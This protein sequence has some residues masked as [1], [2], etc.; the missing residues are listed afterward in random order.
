MIAIGKSISHI[1]ASISY[2][3]KSEK[4]ILLDKNIVSETPHGVS[5]EFRLFQDLNSRCERNT[6]SFVISPSIKDGNRLS[7]EALKAINQSFLEKM[8]LQ[9][10]QYISFVHDNTPHKHIHLYVNRVSKSGEAYKDNY[11]SN[12]SSRAAESIS[13]DMGLAVARKVQHSK[14]TELALQYPSIKNVKEVAQDILKDPSIT[15]VSSFSRSFNQAGSSFNMRTEAYTNKQGDF[16]GL[17]FYITQAGK[18]ARFKA[19]EIDRSL[20][21]QNF[22]DSLNRHKSLCHSIDLSI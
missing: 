7:Q 14:N 18:E 5:R 12:R 9:D 20:S 11:I 19:S 8:E 3:Q 6:L 2:A 21:K 4:G 17:R 22:M 10:H 16:Q 1:S 13:Y 15:T